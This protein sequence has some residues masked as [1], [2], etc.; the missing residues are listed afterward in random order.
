VA[1]PTVT[2]E[3]FTPAIFDALDREITSVFRAGE[4][5]TPDD[6][7]GSYATLNQAVRADNWP[8]LQQ[9]RG[10]VVFLMDQKNMG[11]LYLEASVSEWPHLVHQ[12]RCGHRGRCVH[13]A[14]RCTGGGN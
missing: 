10:K 6:V 8:T 1:F 12:C 9:A 5:I 14:E 2:P 11:P 3:P 7:R 13:R 4:M